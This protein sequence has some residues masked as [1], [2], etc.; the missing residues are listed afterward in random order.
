MLATGGDAADAGRQP[1]VDPSEFLNL[2]V[3]EEEA[4]R[5]VHL[6]G[7]LDMSTAALL[8]DELARLTGDGATH[9]TLD[10]GELAFIDSTGLSVLITALK[11]LRQ[12]GGDMVLR[13]PRPGTQKVLEITGL[14]E[15]FSIV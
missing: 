13:A 9:I 14:T 8:R 4:G 10:L 5:A 7:E 2:V 11:R 12:Q 3:T 15:V 6:R 1:H